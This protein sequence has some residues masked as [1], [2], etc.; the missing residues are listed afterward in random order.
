[1]AMKNVSLGFFFLRKDE[2]D[3]I[4]EAEQAS[5]EDG[6]AVEGKS[7]DKTKQPTVNQPMGENGDHNYGDEEKHDMKPIASTEIEFEDALGNEVL[8]DGSR[9]LHAEA[10]E[11][12]THRL[13]S[14][15]HNEIQQDID[16]HA[17]GGYKIELLE[18]AVGREQCAEDVS[19]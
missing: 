8:Q 9:G 16:D 11:G 17:R 6:A 10:G 19:R 14:W 4:L 18:A 1:M 3:D 13:E 12:G 2:V 5:D 7:D 15:Y